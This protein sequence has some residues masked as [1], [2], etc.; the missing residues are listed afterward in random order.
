MK[1]QFQRSKFKNIYTV[2]VRFSEVDMLNILNNAVYFSYFE[3]AGFHY[4]KN[5]GLLPEEGKLS[6]NWPFY[7]A[8]NEINY[9]QPAFFDDDLN[10]YTRIS[11]I[12]KS[13]FEFEHIVERQK[14]NELL[15]EG[16]GVLVHVDPV[17]K[18]SLKLPVE[19][20]EKISDFDPGVELIKK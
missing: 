5:A 3:Q 12:K 9:L 2:K 1:P 16:K 14:N 8:R 6:D 17:T 11:Y 13:S 4:A 18:R 20:Y 15:S 7:M 10:I 19:F